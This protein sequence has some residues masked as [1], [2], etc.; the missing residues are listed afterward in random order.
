M[1]ASLGWG[2]RFPLS[3]GERA[4][5]RGGRTGRID[6]SKNSDPSAGRDVRT[7]P[8]TGDVSLRHSFRTPSACSQAWTDRV[9]KLRDAL[10]VK[11]RLKSP[12]FH[13]TV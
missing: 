5:V 13:A 4:G 9:E 3:L 6:A 1:A 11:S 10:V 7:V 12:T 8:Q 2:G